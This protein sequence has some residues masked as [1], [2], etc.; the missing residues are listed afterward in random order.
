M[1][2]FPKQRV[3]YTKKTENDYQWCRDT[4]DYLLLNF[5]VDKDVVNAYQSIYDKKLANYRLFNNQL[6]Q[7]DFERE[8]NPLGLEIGQYKDEIQPYNKTYNKI[9]TLLEEEARMPWEYKAVLVNPDGIR[10][11]MAHKDVLFHNYVNFQIQQVLTQLGLEFE[12]DS[13]NPDE[14]IDPREIDSYMNTS[15]L[16]GRE[17]LASMILKVLVKELSLKDVKV[18]AYK[19]GLISGEEVV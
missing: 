1:K 11:K 15:Y 17:H 4:M 3:S 14:L 2:N 13:Y 16:D 6:D 9:Q 10:S 12:Q 8:C 5:G 18:D 19:H 7:A